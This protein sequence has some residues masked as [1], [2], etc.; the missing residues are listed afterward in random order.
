MDWMSQESL[1]G[2]ES[3]SQGCIPLYESRFRIGREAG[4][5]HSGQRG[6]H[7]LSS[8]GWENDSRGRLI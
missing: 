1:L 3:S 4:R 6:R 8:V 2:R 7:I 5:E